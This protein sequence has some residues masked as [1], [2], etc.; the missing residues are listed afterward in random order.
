MVQCF[1]VENPKREKGFIFDLSRGWGNGYLVFNRKHPLHGRHYD[2]INMSNHLPPHGGWTYSEKANDNFFNTINLITIEN[3]ELQID[4]D[5]W[6]IGFDTAHAGDDS[7]NCQ[8]DYVVNHTKQLK[9]YYSK[10]ENF[11]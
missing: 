3:E 8:K 11:I 1:C 7:N 4:A 10:V 6:I 9:E 2:E 5:D